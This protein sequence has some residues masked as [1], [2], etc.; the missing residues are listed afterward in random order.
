VGGIGGGIGEWQSTRRR[1]E[2]GSGGTPGLCAKRRK[3]RRRVSGNDLKARARKQ[4]VS[5][6]DTAFTSAFL[7]DKE[8]TLKFLEIAYRERSPWIVFLQKEP[9]FDFLHSDE[10]YRVLVKKI[11]LPPAWETQR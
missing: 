2:N 5:P 9:V 6:W 1:S 4:Y 10:R 7:G 8:Q 11:G 3:G